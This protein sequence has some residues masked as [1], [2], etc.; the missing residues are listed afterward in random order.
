MKS[1]IVLISGRQGSGKTT[2]ALALQKR[3]WARV[4]HD[5][6]HVT[7]AEPLY[8]M[9]NCVRD[10]CVEY[11]LPAFKKDG[12]LLQYLGTEFGRKRYGEDVW[13]KIA[14]S[15]IS[16]YEAK[17]RD[18]GNTCFVGIVSDTRFQSEV[19]GFPGS[20]KI[21]LLCDEGTR[22]ERIESQPGQ[23]WRTNTSH[24]S[25]V[26]LDTYTSWDLTYDTGILGTEPLRDLVMAAIL[27]RLET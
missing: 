27:K 17:A 26:D 16:D 20:L 13:V 25:E 4:R 14:R 18:Y 12:A 23:S 6:L 2:L 8:V 15:R 24:A 11:G 3:I 22:K 5:C 9:H 21:R 19:A 1:L 7:F 10:T